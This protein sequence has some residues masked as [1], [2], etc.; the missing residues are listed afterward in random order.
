MSAWCPREAVKNMILPACE[1]L[2]GA[3]TGEMIVMSGRWLCEK[4][5]HG[6]ETWGFKV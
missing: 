4:E 5:E 6:T 1:E 3:K 2:A